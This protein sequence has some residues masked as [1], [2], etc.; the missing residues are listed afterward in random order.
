M[1]DNSFLAE[2][3]QGHAIKMLVE[4]LNNC[5]AKTITIRICKKGI[6]FQ[7]M[8]NK[9]TLLID[10]SLERKNFSK[11]VCDTDNEFNFGVNIQKLHTILRPIKKKDFLCLFI[12]K[13]VM[14]LNVR[15]TPDV[16]GRKAASKVETY[17]LRIH[18]V[19]REEVEVP[20]EEF[21]HFPKVIPSSEY[22]KVCKRMGTLGKVTRIRM[23][24]SNYINFSCDCADVINGDIEFGE[25]TGKGENYDTEFITFSLNQIVKIPGLFDQVQIHQPK[26]PDYPLKISSSIGIIGSVNFFIKDRQTIE[27]EETNSRA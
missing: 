22:Q 20:E 17:G 2:T 23:E 24:E 26:N 6:F 3:S 9:G 11:F 1:S 13:D 12:K 16:S 25:R 8:D 10:V 7:H 19:R 4:I 27:K 15:I 21:Y 14:V 5:G 18:T